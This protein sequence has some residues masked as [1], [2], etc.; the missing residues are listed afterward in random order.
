MN[1]VTPKVGAK[2]KLLF[3]KPDSDLTLKLK[4][5]LEK[6]TG[7]KHSTLLETFVNY[8]RKKFYNIV[9]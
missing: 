6:L 5:Y 8:G 1:L 4:A 3:N 2:H 7:D 9:P